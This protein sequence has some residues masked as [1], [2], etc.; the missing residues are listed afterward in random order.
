MR[1]SGESSV[2]IISAEQARRLYAAHLDLH[3]LRAG[4]PRL[5]AFARR[6]ATVLGVK[7]AVF[8]KRERHWV[9]IAQSDPNPPLAVDRAVIDKLTQLP[10]IVSVESWTHDEHEWTFL[11]CKAPP[12]QPTVLAIEGDWTVSSPVLL[13]VA[14]NVSFVLRAWAAENRARLRLSTHRLARNLARPH[15]RQALFD[16]IIEHL[17]R[18]VKAR[19][20]ALA[21]PNP[22]DGRLSVVSTY[23]Y[24][25]ALVEHLRIE[26]GVGVL[27]LV[28]QTG[29]LLQVRDV[30]DCPKRA[31]RRPRYRR[32]SFIAMPIR[33][34]HEVLG[35]VAVTDRQDA[36]PFTRD[37]VSTLRA[38][39]APVA[40]TLSRERALA[41]AESYAHAAA[42][43]PLSGAFNRRYFHA[44]L[45]EELQRSRRHQIPL[46]L[47]MID[48]DNFKAINDS[49]G[50]LTGDMVIKD[51][52]EILRRA[53]RVFDVC[54]RFGGEEFAIVMPGSTA[55]SATSIAERIR[56]RIEQYRPA[57]RLLSG[58]HVT[59][60]IGVAVSARDVTGRDLI[61][62]ADRALYRAKRDGKNRVCVDSTAPPRL[63]ALD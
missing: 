18:G 27:G 35:V 23:G 50:H 59:A 8:T 28:F 2:R 54:A 33:A 53:V 30:R 58:L 1:S 12:A 32:E 21:L 41:Q 60:S 26:P 24:P 61:D 37:D 6:L 43:D 17:T 19:I 34:G 63:P 39:L 48:I 44:R 4:E 7:V 20:G 62:H 46:A 36:G 55:E 15:G 5:D 25:L 10:T 9:L 29:E 22:S 52:A 47:L 16:L 57:D 51:I 13:L 14:E 38:L 45:E 11:V 42:L 31:G 49:Y 3:A 40:L 56:E